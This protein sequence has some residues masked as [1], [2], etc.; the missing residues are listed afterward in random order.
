MLGE[1][2]H[3]TV[4]F[5]DIGGS[6]ELIDQ[7]DPEEALE[8]LGPIL[9]RLMDGVHQHDGLVNQTRGDGIMALFGAPIASEDHAV[10]ACRAALAIR[11]TIDEFNRSRGLRIKIRIGINSGQV[12]I[13]SIGSNLTM[14]YDAVG[15]TVHL[16]A[17]METLAAPDTIKL[18]SDT[19]DLAKGFISALPLGAE[20]AKGVSDPVQ[21]YELVAMR[22]RTRWQARS[23]GGLS[24]LAGRQSELAHLNSAL[25]TAAAAT[26]HALTIVGGAGIGKSRLLHEF[27]A[28]VSDEWLVLQTACTPQHTNSSYYPVSTLMRAMFG[29]RAGD[30]PAAAATRARAQ[31]TKLSPELTVHLPAI[32]SLLDL[33]SDDADW[34]N[35]EPPERRR[36]IN[37]AIT[38]LIFHQERLTPLVILIED[39]HWIDAE[40]RLVLDNF[41]RSIG[42]ARIL[43][44]A[45]QRPE[46]MW[47]GSKIGRLDLAP[48]D[49][50]DG[51]RL[52]DA[53]LGDDGSLG[54]IRRRI[55]AQAQGN[56]LFVEELALALKG[57]NVLVGDSGKYKVSNAATGIEIPET[58]HSVLASR[59]DLLDRATKSLL[60]MA[61]V[62]GKD[63]S[64]SVLS[65]M[66]GVEPD[67]LEPRLQMLE[68]SDFLWSIRTSN[69]VEY[70]FKHELIREVAYGMLL[71]S[72]RRNLHAKATETIELRFSDRLD[73]HIDRLADHAYRAELWQKAVPYQLR[74]CRR[75]VKRGANQDAIA[76]YERGLETLSHWPDSR[77]KMISE[78]DLHLTVVTAFEPLGM[79]RRIA[80]VLR[81]SRRLADISGEPWRIAA[82]NC[83]LAVG[84][85]RLGYHTEAMTAAQNAQS[86]AEQVGEPVLIFAALHQVGI[87]YHEIGAFAQ[88]LAFH[89]KCLAMETP[90][91]DERREG[92]AALPSVVLRTFMAD[93]LI[94]LGELDRAEKLAE[95][96][97]QRAKAA[98]HVYSRANI[99]HVFGRLRTA[100]GRP[101]EALSLLHES[102]QTCVDLEMKQM[103]PVFASRMGEAYLALGDVAA[104]LEILAVPER[105]DMPLAEHAF[106]WRFL[107]IAQ[108]RALL[109]AG[110]AE[111]A[112]IVAERALALAEE[113]GEPP[114]L[115]NAKKLLGDISRVIDD[116]NPAQ[117]ER[118]Y[119]EA[120]ALAEQCAMRPMMTSCSDA[121]AALAG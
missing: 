13:H 42:N 31:V 68:A 100:Q 29:V 58:I 52:L 97:S 56:P 41:V 70:S 75:A 73:E 94:D 112:K 6:T 93:S 66:A 59:I 60:Q 116:A 90:Q 44:V 121:L 92:W 119:R 20:S 5:A 10:Q 63:I 120:F 45:T 39:V 50:T 30:T 17:R 89:E 36:K 86:I 76:I 16:A 117:A 77:K 19:F 54:P 95:E 7:L 37:E 102:W 11:E 111:E 51:D 57:T 3:V 8:A 109:A 84:L 115:A 49:Q 9:K 65:G 81:E 118:Y 15:K 104:A 85:W 55:L 47:S 14:N 106:G 61:A 103:Y 35:L 32:F 113:R 1:R 18:T 105:L 83:Q 62:I 64:T 91:I 25:D 79:H 114:Q 87:I 21:T 26:G 98:N 43:V 107:F 88:S 108:G 22:P 72:A 23:S 33:S 99:N 96:A 34:K 2:K 69:M 110:R 46:R 82:V 27:I 53:L 78:I 38:A 71:L 80:E 28:N 48:L 40:T 101:A 67:E 24:T 12:V 74:S 4:L